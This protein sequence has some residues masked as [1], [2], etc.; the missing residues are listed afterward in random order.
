MRTKKETLSNTKYTFQFS[1]T[2]SEYFRIWIVNLLLSVL[3]LGI[4][5]AW[6]K[7]RKNQYFYQNA[8]LDGSNF[9]YHGKPL[10]IL[11]GRII[12]ALLI[13]GLNFSQYLSIYLYLVVMI[14]FLL[15][16]PWLISR[17]I[18]F[19][20]RNSS[21]RGIR[22]KF[23]GN[24]VDAAKVLYGY[25]FL[26]GITFG[27][28]Y[29]LMYHRIRKFIFDNSA[30]GSFRSG[31]FF[32]TGSVYGVFFLTAGLAFCSVLIIFTIIKLVV[33]AIAFLF[34][35]LDPNLIWLT[36]FLFYAVFFLLIFPYFQANMTNLTWNN[37]K[38]G[39]VKFESTQKTKDLIRIWGGN[40]LFTVLSLGI[41]W[42]WAVV[43]V[44]RYRAET[45]AVDAQSGLDGFTAAPGQNITAAG[46]EVTDAFD[47]EF[48]F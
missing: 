21:W 27:I 20:L 11:K 14:F 6:A 23:H 35:V 34:G 9:D 32:S 26:T 41:Y 15:A 37:I 2:G 47:I 22:F 7:V 12:A 3:T 28:C 48:S 33:P 46:E 16:F 24:A 8:T 30:F 5:S 38:L 17:S 42:P 29:P 43:R 45:M 44:A 40:L 18:A 13:I 1:G 36:P 4:Y 39:T 19:N 25:G 10:A 31:I